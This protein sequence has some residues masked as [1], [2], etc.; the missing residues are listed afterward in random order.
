M[1]R[2]LLRQ[3]LRLVLVAQQN[4]GGLLQDLLDSIGG[5]EEDEDGR[6]AAT[7]AGTCVGR[8]DEAAARGLGAMREEAGTAAGSGM[9]P[10]GEDSQ[11]RDYGAAGSRTERSSEVPSAGAAAVNT[12]AGSEVAAVGG[13]GTEAEAGAETE[14]VPE[15]GAYAGAETGAGAGAEAEAAAGTEEDADPEV[16]PRAGDATASPLLPVAADR[17][18]LAAGAEVRATAGP[19]PPHPSLA[20]N[21]CEAGTAAGVGSGAASVFTTEGGGGDNSGLKKEPSTDM[22]KQYRAVQLEFQQQLFQTLVPTGEGGWLTAEDC[23]EAVALMLTKVSLQGEEG[24]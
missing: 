19:A 13:V 12:A 14:A 9:S 15:E 16:G 6:G 24:V 21:A 17:Q 10:A 2:H 20:S 3:K 8:G 11:Q 22:L 1:D 23:R 7:A 5:E 18:R 4:L